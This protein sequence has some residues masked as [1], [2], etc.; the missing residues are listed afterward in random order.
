MAESQNAASNAETG[1]G[2]EVTEIDLAKSIQ[3]LEA[4]LNDEDEG[5]EDIEKA[6]IGASGGLQHVTPQDIV[7]DPTLEDEEDEEDEDA[8]PGLDNPMPGNEPKAVEQG[9]AKSLGAEEDADVSFAKS[10][11]AAFAG[12][13]EIVDVA[14]GS[15]FAKALVMSTIEGLSI[16]HDEMHKSLSEM[17]T[18]QSAQVNALAKSMVTLS[19]ALGEVLAEV[20]GVANSPVRPAPKSARY[21]QKSFGGEEATST[22]SKAQVCEVLEQRVIAGRLDPLV[23]TKFESTGEINPA[24]LAEIQRGSAQ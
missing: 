11:S 7:L 16:A 2:A 17:E 1:D 19:K 8:P 6:L 13:E 18:R 20:K 4:F 12:S 9:I 14:R 21:L 24:L 23:L 5:A 3:M 15:D 10:L 22:L